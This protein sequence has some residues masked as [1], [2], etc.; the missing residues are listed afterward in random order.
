MEK[1][2]N[3]ISFKEFCDPD[4]RRN[5]QMKIK[6]EA[7]WVTFLELNGI[8]NISKFANQYFGK[9]QSWFSQRINGY[10]VNHKKATFKP[11]DYDRIVESLRNLAARLNEYADAIEKAEL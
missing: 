7:V 8:I 5:E 9:S 4:W 1:E 6:S 10:D 11:E 3:K 2:V